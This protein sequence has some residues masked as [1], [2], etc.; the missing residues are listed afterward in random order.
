MKTNPLRMSALDCEIL[1]SAF[2]KAVIEE[3]I[4]EN[5]WRDYATQ[6]VRDFARIETVD[7]GLLEW[8]MRK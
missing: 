6:M 7:P 8:I 2:H 3:K 4:P 1:R 5:Q